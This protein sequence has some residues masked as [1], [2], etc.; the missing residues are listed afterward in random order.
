MQASQQPQPKFSALA[1]GQ[2]KS[3]FQRTPEEVNALEAMRQSYHQFADKAETRSR[4][5][6]DIMDGNSGI[7][8]NVENKLEKVIIDLLDSAL[9]QRLK[10][11]HQLSTGSWVYKDAV[12]SRFGHVLGSA[13]LTTQ[14]LDSLGRHAPKPIKDQIEEYGPA[15]V[16][17][18]L[19]HD[20]GHIAP[21]SHIAQRVWFP[22]ERDMHE[23]VSQR[24][25]REDAGFRL[26]LE[27]AISPEGARKLDLIVTESSQVPKWT[28]QLI[29][30]GG[31]NIDRGDWVP[32][33]GL[34]CGVSYGRYDLPIIKKNLTI[35]ETGEL[36]MGEAGVTA[37]ES[38]FTARAYMYQNVYGHKISKIGEMMHV[39]LGRRARELF[40]K[41]DSIYADETMQAV[42]S[43]K[44]SSELSLAT[45]L[46][47]VEH[48]WSSHLTHWGKSD[49]LTLSELSQRIQLR[50]PFKH[51]NPEASS[52][53]ILLKLVEASGLDPDYFFVRMHG[54]EVKLRED[55]DK[56]FKVVTKAGKLKPLTE[57][58]KFMNALSDIEKFQSEPFIAV[59]MDVFKHF[60]AQ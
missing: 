54:P 3:V 9:V 48:W 30:S 4:L 27:K 17:F 44:S 12:H 60:K 23:E 59:P 2:I 40:A 53:A 16:A 10:Y 32:R 31:W 39:A 6:R 38:F 41:G 19:T 5:M 14:I 25:L 29:T 36:G 42:L 11:V 34:Y 35:T 57:Y 56:A 52:A 37:L 47:M 22:D 49:D 7:E 28:W 45:M 51:F 21:G 18:A 1:S 15:V 26:E 58:S 13:Y 33:D 46:N 55:L 50:Q 20:L 8:L 24:M 43:S